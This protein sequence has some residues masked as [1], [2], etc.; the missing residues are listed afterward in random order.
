MAALQCRRTSTQFFTAR[1]RGSVSVALA[2][3]V[4]ERSSD[5]LLSCFSRVC[6]TV[7]MLKPSLLGKVIGNCERRVLQKVDE[8]LCLYLST[9]GLLSVLLGT[10]ET[11]RQVQFLT[12]VLQH[13]TQLPGIQ[14]VEHFLSRFASCLQDMLLRHFSV[15]A[16][17]LQNHRRRSV[18]G[19]VTHAQ[20]YL[21]RRSDAQAIAAA[22]DMYSELY[23]PSSVPVVPR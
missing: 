14:V 16:A 19:G 2:I 20:V 10:V 1:R 23:V 7:Y 5:S 3:K 8:E 17:L 4:A 12:P 18:E 22:S 15:I 11:N 21:S 9:H 6:A 13:R